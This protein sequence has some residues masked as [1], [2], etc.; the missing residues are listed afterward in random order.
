MAIVPTD[1]AIDD[2]F[3]EGVTVSEVDKVVIKRLASIEQRLRL[4]EGD[5]QRQLELDADL[6]LS[7]LTA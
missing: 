2:A 7:G 4:L 6:F 3:G 5:F 1:E